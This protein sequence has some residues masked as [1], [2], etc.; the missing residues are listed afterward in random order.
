MGGMISAWYTVIAVLACARITRLI[1]RDR[2][3]Q[4]LRMRAVNRLGIESWG[5]YLIQCDWCT[6]L[7]V[8]AV[9]MPAAWWWGHSPWL[10]L[11]LLVLAAAYAIGWTA[12][13]EGGE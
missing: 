9:V 6:G 8:A 10:Q 2:I 5:A 13:R 7:W 4:P 12:S 3:T 11:P 1:T